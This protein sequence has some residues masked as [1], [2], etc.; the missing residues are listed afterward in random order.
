[1]LILHHGGYAE[2]EALLR[3]AVADQERVVAARPRDVESQARLGEVR[4]GLADFLGGRGQWDEALVVLRENLRTNE[5]LARRFPTG[6]PASYIRLVASWEQLGRCLALAGRGDE[7]EEAFRAA[8]RYDEHLARHFPKPPTVREETRGVRGR[9]GELLLRRGKWAEAEVCLTEAVRELEAARA[10]FPGVEAYRDCL[11]FCL[12]ARGK[13]HYLADRLPEAEAS[14]RR[15][16]ELT[17][18]VTPSAYKDHCQVGVLLLCPLPPLRDAA[19]ALALLRKA[20]RDYPVAGLPDWQHGVALCRAGELALAIGDLN[21]HVSRPGPGRLQCL[22][23]LALAH[24]QLGQREQARQYYDEA[25]RALRAVPL[26]E[27]DLLVLNKEIA[28]ALRRERP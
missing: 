20:D 7:A 6:H 14:F 27:T 18:G 23:F 24:Q 8:V 3:Q 4:S 16:L 22:F 19:K 17:D 12:N 9:L 10:A 5:E 28:A 2:G 11:I 15:C 13:L 26:P 25:V 1:M 21:Q